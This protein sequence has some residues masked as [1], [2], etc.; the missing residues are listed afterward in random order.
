MM[1]LILTPILYDWSVDNREVKLKEKYGAQKKVCESNYDKMWKTIKQIASVSEEY[2]ESF[3]DMYKNMMEGRYKEATLMKWVHEDN[4]DF[5]TSLYEDL[6]VAIEANRAQFD[7]E[8]KKLTAI[9]EQHRVLR[10]TKPAKWFINDDVVEID[11][12][13]IT[14]TKTAKVFE[15]GKDDDIE[16]FYKK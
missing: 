15:S 14:S 9:N 8:Q 11:H 12:R 6:N 7:N 13:I 2:K 1:I 3:S 5:S 4:P 16:L 10:Q